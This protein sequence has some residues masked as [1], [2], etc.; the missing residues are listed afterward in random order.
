MTQIFAITFPTI[1]LISTMVSAAKSFEL[2]PKNLIPIRKQVIEV[3]FIC[4]NIPY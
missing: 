2:R 3:S 1:K 4:L